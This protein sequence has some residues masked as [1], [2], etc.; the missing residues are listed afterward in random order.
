MSRIR[1]A[2]QSAPASR[3]LE[4]KRM[5]G[6][7]VAAVVSNHSF[8]QKGQSGKRVSRAKGS[9]TGSTFGSRPLSSLTP[10]LAPDPFPRTVRRFALHIVP[11]GMVRIRHYG[12]LAHRDRGERLALCRSPLG[13]GAKPGPAPAATSASP[14]GGEGSPDGLA[15]AGGAGTE[16]SR[17]EPRPGATSRVGVGV[18]AVLAAPVVGRDEEASSAASPGE[19]PAAVR[20][21]VA[22]RCPACGVGP[23]RTTWWADRPGRRQRHRMAILDSS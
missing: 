18:L 21:A 3:L 6:D 16:P 13:V 23:V 10:F 22:D 17:V 14:P 5:S 11:K 20:V 4:R 2:D 7:E 19:P 1:G 9:R 15:T 12:L 8:G